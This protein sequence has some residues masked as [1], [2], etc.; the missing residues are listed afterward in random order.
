[1]TYWNSLLAKVDIRND[2]W[3]VQRAFSDACKEKEMALFGA[4][5]NEG[6]WLIIW[7]CD[8]ET[9]GAEAASSVWSSWLGY[10]HQAQ[11]LHYVH[12]YHTHTLAPTRTQK[13]SKRRRGYWLERAWAGLLYTLHR[14][15]ERAPFQYNST[16]AE[17]RIAWNQGTYYS[18]NIDIHRY[19][20]NTFLDKVWDLLWVWLKSIVV[21]AH[22]TWLCI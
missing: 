20:T 12:V 10:P 6:N 4:T 18:E 17:W 19:K 9:T 11:A 2:Q 14:R 21:T 16:S 13:I 8:C 5:R 22:S 3:L 1:M 7:N 15:K